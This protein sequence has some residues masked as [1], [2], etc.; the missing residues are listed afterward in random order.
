VGRII[1]SP[2]G[3][4]ESHLLSSSARA[5]GQDLRRGANALVTVHIV[6]RL[7]DAED[8]VRRRR[9]DEYR[10]H[11]AS[12]RAARIDPNPHQIDAV[13]FALTRIPDGGCILA[14]EVGLG[15]TIEA[16]LVVAQ[17]LAE[18]AKRVLIVTPK[19]LLGQ[20]RQELFSLFGIETRE[21]T[22]DNRG[23][24]GNGV[25]LATRDLV[26]S[27]TGSVALQASERFDLCVIDEAH[28]VFAGI[29]R[30]Y[31][32]SGSIREDSPFARMAA[33]LSSA[34][35]ATGTP[36]LL[37]TATPIQNSLL[38][39]W[40]LV[41]YVDA[42]GT[43]LGDLSTFRQIF[44]PTDDRILE[45]GQEHE[46]QRRLS[47]VMQRTLRGQAQEFMHEP[48]MGRQAR[49]FEYPMSPQER[50]LYDDVT[51]YLLEPGIYAFSGKQRQLLLLGVSSPDGV[52]PPRAVEKPGEGRRATPPDARWPERRR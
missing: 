12:Q 27:E 13:I 10:R 5:G 29:Y 34:I 41:H 52:I 36:V 32:R 9:A 38:E 4:R 28:E 30:R 17:M 18:G 47:T 1:E 23:F 6:Q 8:L 50:E 19:A 24:D 44:C 49:L 31:D 22:R 2:A 35:S 39:L 3:L 51:N 33:R 46:L 14:D 43:L 25:F 15:K 48:F 16:G 45:K 40:G 20:W 21:V 42:T 11:V 26:G 7:L 37:L